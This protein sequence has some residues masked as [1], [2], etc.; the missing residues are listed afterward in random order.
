MEVC[1]K[2]KKWQ[3]G[4]ERV[5]AFIEGKKNVYDE[6]LSGRPTVINKDLVKHL[7]KE[8]AKRGALLLIWEIYDFHLLAKLY[9]GGHIENYKRYSY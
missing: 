4:A 9:G 5:Y 3:K 7:T 1:G 2:C 8:F 6:K